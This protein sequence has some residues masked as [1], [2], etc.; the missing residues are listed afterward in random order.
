MVTA[1]ELA[2]NMST[3]NATG[4]VTAKDVATTRASEKRM[5][6]FDQRSA[7]SRSVAQDPKILEL[8]TAGW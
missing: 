8:V 5:V 6:A 1:D 4:M 7:A 2:R 3:T